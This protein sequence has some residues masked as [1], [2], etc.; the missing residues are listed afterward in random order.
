M[1]F[2][3]S[4]A[5]NTHFNVLRRHFKQ[6]IDAPDAEYYGNYCYVRRDLLGLFVLRA[7]H[8]NF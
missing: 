5:E 8:N 1:P 4:E 2:S 7:L 3:K 6:N